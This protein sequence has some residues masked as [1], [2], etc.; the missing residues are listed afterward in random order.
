MNSKTLIP[1]AAALAGFALGWGVRPASRADS[2]SQSPTGEA[3]KGGS[4]SGTGSDAA[5]PGRTSRPVIPKSTLAP[6]TP[7]EDVIVRQQRLEKAFR[8]SGSV[9]DRAKLV[10]MAEALGLSTEQ[11]DQFDALLAE[12]RQQPV[13]SST[14]LSPKARLEKMAESARAFDAKFRTMLGPEQAAALETLRA[15]QA[16]NRTEARTQRELADFIDRVDVSP[17][18][19]DAVAE[20]LRASATKEAA[21]LPAGTEL[22]MESGYLP[23]GIGSISDRSIQAI[24]A[25]GD[26]ASAALDPMAVSR[27]MADQQREKILSHAMLLEGILTPAQLAQY[28]AVAE[29]QNAFNGAGGPVQKP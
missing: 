20:V 9:R 22:L 29:A 28:R 26:D 3:T 6:V 13:E 18:Q 11:L 25:I 2:V 10:R 17:E 7:T 15:R 12:Q 23:S 4:G 21:N 27:K 19:R 14:G 5:R 1:I 16:E 8:D 24:M